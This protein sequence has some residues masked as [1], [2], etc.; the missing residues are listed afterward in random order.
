M[1]PLKKRVIPILIT[2]LMSAI[3]PV[4]PM[5]AAYETDA[6]YDGYIVKLK[7][8][9]SAMRLF[10]VGSALSNAEYAG[11]GLYAVQTEEEAFALADYAEY[12]EPN[13]I[14]TLFGTYSYTDY[15]AQDNITMTN[16]EGLWTYDHFGTGIKVGVIDSGVSPHNALAANLLEGYNYLDKNRETADSIGHGTRVAGTLA[17]QY[18]FEVIGAAHNAKIVPLKCFGEKGG[19]MLDVVQAIYD[20][21]DLYGCDVLNMSFGIE[22]IDIS[23]ISEAVEY[24]ASLGVVM[25]AAAGNNGDNTLCYPAAYPSVIGVGSVEKSGNTV[26]KSSFSNYNKSV[27]VTAPGRNT[28]S[29]SASSK[30]AYSIDSGTS[31]AAPVVAGFAANVLSADPSLRTGD[32]RTVDLMKFIIADTAVDLGAAGCDDY[33]GYGMI[34]GGKIKAALVS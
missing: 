34:D 18:G 9:E 1:N 30:T 8:P 20:G 12:I 16:A 3:A 24:A 28:K 31:Y 6:P 5:A 33:F 25:V 29:L 15:A 4:P 32:A 22:N 19:S 13:Y 7:N 23:T 21:V 14:L 26:I 11:H 10:A 27:F 17:A 2:L